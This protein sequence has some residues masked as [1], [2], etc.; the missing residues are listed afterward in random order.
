MGYE[1]VVVT[2]GVAGSGNKIRPPFE[3]ACQNTPTGSLRV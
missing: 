1:D 3:R 2:V